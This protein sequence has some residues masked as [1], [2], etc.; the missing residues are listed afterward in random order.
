MVWFGPKNSHKTAPNS[1]NMGLQMAAMEFPPQK[2]LDHLG[3]SKTVV[4]A[5]LTPFWT[6]LRKLL[7]PKRPSNGPFW[8]GKEVTLWPK[9]WVFKDD[10]G[11][12]GVLKHTF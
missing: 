8:D 1:P 9:K 6:I 12:F 4:Q 7:G 11:P 3:C 10:R 5:V 2:T